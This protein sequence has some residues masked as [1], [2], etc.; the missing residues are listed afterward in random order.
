M[1]KKSLALMPAA[2][3]LPSVAGSTIGIVGAMD[4]EVEALLPK[5]QN[6]QVKKLVAI[7]FIWVS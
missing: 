6:Q 3:S 1:L 4:V 2:Y 7:A 5:I